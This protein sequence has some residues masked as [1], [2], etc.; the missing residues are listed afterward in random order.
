M[1]AWGVEHPF[2]RKQKR[3]FPDPQWHRSKVNL[4]LCWQLCFFVSHKV[5]FSFYPQTTQQMS[6]HFFRGVEGSR[7]IG[8]GIWRG[9]TSRPICPASTSLVSPDQR[10]FLEDLSRGVP[11]T[12]T[13]KLGCSHCFFHGDTPGLRSVRLGRPFASGFTAV[14]MTVRIKGVRYCWAGWV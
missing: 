14:L 6:I 3:Q 7:R 2:C 12:F 4:A 10:C 1:V 9:P 8:R 11:S 5:S 13:H